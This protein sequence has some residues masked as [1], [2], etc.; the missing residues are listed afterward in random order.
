MEKHFQQEYQVTEPTLK[1]SAE[2]AE[3]QPDVVIDEMSQFDL[4]NGL[5]ACPHGVIAM[6]QTIPNFVET[7]T[8]FASCKK[9]EGYFFIQTSQRSSI[10]SSKQDIANMVEAVWSLADADVE[11]TDGY[12]GWAPNPDSAILDIAVSCYKKRFKKEPKVRA[13]HAGLECGLIGDKIPGMDMISFGPT[14]R[15]VHSPDERCEIATVQMFWDFMCDILKNAPKAEAPKTKKV[16]AAKK[17]TAKKTIAEKKATAKK[18]SA[19]KT[20]KK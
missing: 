8:N 9:K 2:V 13:I 20:A 6:S 19:K 16:A 4:L 17:A 15:G 12:P 18:V 10:E 14:L 7:S 11:H 1:L 5:Y 3:V